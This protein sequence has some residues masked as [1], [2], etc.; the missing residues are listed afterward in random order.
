[1]LLPA[2][3]AFLA[4]HSSVIARIETEL[5]ESG[6]ISLAWYDILIELERA[7]AGRLKQN[8]LAQACILTKSGIS[9]TLDVLQKERLLRR[10]TD[11]ED[12]RSNYAVISELGRQRLKEAWPVYRSCILKYFD[13]ER[14][15]LTSLQTAFVALTLRLQK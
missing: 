9:R 12:R 13:L 3:K 6:Q 1:M 14:D 4:F 2:W 15:D 11:S 5:R 7:P 8:S 10:E